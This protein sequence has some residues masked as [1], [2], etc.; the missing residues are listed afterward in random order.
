[1]SNADLVA[2]EDEFGDVVMSDG[3]DPTGHQRLEELAKL[4]AVNTGSKKARSSWANDPVRCST[5]G[6]PWLG[7]G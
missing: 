4:G 6:L 3:E 1:M 2:A 5:V 7:T